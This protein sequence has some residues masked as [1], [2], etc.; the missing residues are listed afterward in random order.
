MDG[1][2]RGE[3]FHVAAV[4]GPDVDAAEQHALQR[5]EDLW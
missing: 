5:R 1:A 2:A 3:A 4:P